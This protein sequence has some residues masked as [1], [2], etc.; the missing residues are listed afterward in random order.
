MERPFIP[1][2]NR[3]VSAIPDIFEQ[4]VEAVEADNAEYS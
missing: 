2:W 3:V 4:L 1:S